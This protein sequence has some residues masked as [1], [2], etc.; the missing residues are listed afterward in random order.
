MHLGVLQTGRIPE[1]MI[2]R[3]DEYPE[4]FAE[5]YQAADPDVRVSGFAIVDSQFPET[6]T[7]CDAWLVTGSKFGV[8]DDEPWIEP[9]KDFLRAA[10]AAEVPMIGICFGHQIMAEAFGGRAEKFHGGWGCGVHNYTMVEAPGWLGGERS[11][12]SMHA[13]HQ[14]QVTKLADDATVLATSEFCQNAMLSYGDPEAPDAISIQPHP[15]FAVDFAREIV[16]LRAGELIP[17]E[18]SVPALESFGRPVHGAAF[19]DWSLTYLRRALAARAA[20]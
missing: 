6:P 4:Q 9:L 12:F 1:T 19:V 7:A 5:I 17:P 16:E 20:A 11:G 8:Y 2:D 3:Y 14:D 10:R 18:K 13:M 15:E